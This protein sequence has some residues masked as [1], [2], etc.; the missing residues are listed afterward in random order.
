MH[1]VSLGGTIRDYL[2][3]EERDNTTYEDLRQALARFLVEERGFARQSLVPRYTVEYEVKGERL[4]READIAFL[5]PD[6][7]PGL[8]VVFCAGQIHTYVREVTSMARLAL[9]LPCPLAVVTDTRE[10][11]LFSVRDG[12]VLAHGLAAL[13]GQTRTAELARE[14]ALLP[15]SAEQ[16]ERESRILHTYTGFLKTCCG[17]SCSL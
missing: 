16:R 13:P 2:T 3:G 11:E 9:P 8:F 1:E 17:E 6:A 5:L 7:S 10:A 4:Q 14:H 15:L 12:S